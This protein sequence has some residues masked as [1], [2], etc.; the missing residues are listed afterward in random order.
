MEKLIYRSQALASEKE[1]LRRDFAL[2]QSTEGYSKLTPRQQEIIRVSLLLQAR[3][4][5]TLEVSKPKSWPLR[6]FCQDSEVFFQNPECQDHIE[7]WYCHAA[8]ASLESGQLSGDFPPKH[9]DSFFNA[10]Y[11]EIHNIQEIKKAILFFGFPSVVHINSEPENL[12]GED[13]Q[14]HSFLAL[15]YDQA[16]NI[17]VWEKEGFC[18]PYRITTLKQVYGEYKNFEYWGVRKLR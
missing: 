13:S 7:S 9:P 14:Y 8:I 10:A 2:L 6:L 15:G 3:A 4:D 17:V 5:R 11:F 16:K 18:Y 1:K 12:T